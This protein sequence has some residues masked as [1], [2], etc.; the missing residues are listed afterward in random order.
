MGSGTRAGN[1]LNFQVTA[2]YD[3]TANDLGLWQRAFSKASELL[4]NATQGQL[5]FGTIWVTDQLLGAS[6]AEFI[7]DPNTAG[8]ALATFGR[9]GEQGRAIQLP[10]YAQEQVLSIIHELGHH[11][12]ALDEE[13]AR[14]EAAQIDTSAM[15]PGGHG[16][17]I[18]PLV[19]TDLDEPDAD[20]AGASTIIIFSGQPVETQSITSKVGN[21][22]N[23]A[24]GF[25]QNPQNDANG[26]TTIQWTTGVECTNDRTTGACIMEFSRSNAGTLAPN[27]VWTPAANPVTEFCT[28]ANHDSD[29]DTGQ[30]AR[31]GESCWRTIGGA[32]GFA[33]LGEPD[34]TQDAA[35]AQPGGWVAPTWTVLDPTIRLALVLDRSGSMNRNGGA[36]LRGV[37]TGAQYWVENA[38]VEDDFLSIVWYNSGTSTLLPLTEFSTL[39]SG[40]VQNLVT[41]I[42]NQGAVG[43]TNIVDGLTEALTELTA[44]GSL[45]SVQASLLIT[46][47]AHNTPPGTAMSDVVPAYNA[48]NADIYTLG[49]GAGNEM[50]LPGLEDLAAATGGTSVQAGDGDDANAIEQA[51]IE[52]N[53][54][55]R[56]GV[57][58]T[59][60]S[61]GSDTSR[62]DD[63][64]DDLGDEADKVPPQK[65]PTLDELADE[66]KMVHWQKAMDPGTKAPHRFTWFTIDVEEG[67]DATTFTLLHDEKATYWMY[68]IDPNGREV[69][70]SD[71]DVIAWVAPEQNFEFAKME[72][73][74]P[75]QWTVLGLR[76][77]RGPAVFTRAIAALDHRDVIVWANAIQDGG[78]C[79][80]K[81][82]AGARF[83]EPLT[84]LTAT[85]RVR[86]LETGL[87]HRIA[88]RDH[89]GDGEYCAWVELP[90]G[91]YS[92][93]VHI[94][95]PRNPTVADFG[96]AVLH[97][98]N[99]KEIGDPTI[100]AGPFVR[101]AAISFTVGGVKVPK[102]VPEDE[103]G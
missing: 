89:A 26:W 63:R 46:D 88:L 29:N 38:A 2:N 59:S 30:Q 25:S 21:R 81:I 75:G 12:F 82:T 9:W 66:F 54:E 100:K 64:L 69:H 79:P 24:S 71:G 1:L 36:R 92:G 95:S 55:I 76:F 10:A 3:L 15:L 61:G 40:D 32:A 93:H 4:W 72:R 74:E 44:P 14:A 94:S 80:V 73:P 91:R 62:V 31:H 47:G 48:A 22:I 102:G 5:R 50:D 84:G 86:S 27:G 33:D 45:A 42:E 18:I 49:V 34:H 99:P 20:Y 6:N 19:E 58:S 11:L 83:R 67:V 28:D 98:E 16:N 17:Q 57:I 35:T 60:G 23:V 97:A 37:K 96:H 52:L 101:D 39:S 41:D 103:K 7:L 68:L 90:A 65:R 8:R 53:G 77:D 13:Y 87:I 70:P 56:G 85:A 43:G 78:R 51:M